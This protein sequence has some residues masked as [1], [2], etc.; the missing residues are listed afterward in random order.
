MSQKSVSYSESKTNKLR[1]ILRKLITE[2][3]VTDKDL[4]RTLNIPNSTLNQ[5][6]NAEHLRPRIDTLI[7]I[8]KYFNI[9]IEQLI[10]E[11]P[12]SKKELTISYSKVPANSIDGKWEPDLFSK[13]VEVTSQLIK[14][15]N[16]KVT[17]K[18]VISIIKESYFFSLNKRDKEV[19]KSFIEWLFENLDRNS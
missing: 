18:Q 12:L 3:G 5:L 4:A 11:K 2:A 10:G 16:Y 9:S 7:P 15:N 8:A 17:A 6:L 14:Q 1:L 19:D 13:C